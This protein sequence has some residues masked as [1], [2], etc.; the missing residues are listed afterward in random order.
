MS[1]LMRIQNGDEQQLERLIESTYPKIYSYLLRRL[2]DITIAKDFTQET[3]LRFMKHLSSLPSD[4]KV[5]NYLYRIAYHLCMDY[6]RIYQREQEEIEV[7]SQ[8]KLPIEVVLQ[9]EK[10]A[11]IQEA[12]ACLSDEQ[13]DVILLRYYQDLK[14]K[15]IAYI[16]NEKES[17]VKTRLRLGMK[18]LA[19]ILERS[20]WRE[21]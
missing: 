2:R 3:F 4:T 19:A 7:S 21:Y 5:E 1:V 16:L 12:I 17:T 11:Q 18:K 14:I 13:K 9:K 15:E 6:F 8:D 10:E 20:D